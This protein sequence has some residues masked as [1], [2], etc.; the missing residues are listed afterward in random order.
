[1]EL[2]CPSIESNLHKTKWELDLSMIWAVNEQSLII[3]F[4]RIQF[5]WN[6][7]QLKYHKVELNSRCE[8]DDV[9]LCCMLYTD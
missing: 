5:R 1:M 4:N 9:M 2:S 7:S 6:K 8:R 3:V